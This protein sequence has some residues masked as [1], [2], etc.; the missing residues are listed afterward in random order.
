MRYDSA[1]LSDFFQAV[2]HERENCLDIRISRVRNVF[3]PMLGLPPNLLAMLGSIGGAV[4]YV[5]IEYT[6]SHT[7]CNLRSSNLS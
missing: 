1:L 4:Q 2:V 6:E 5:S 3:W 7:D